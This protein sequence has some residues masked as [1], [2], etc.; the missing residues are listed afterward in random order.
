M[1]TRQRPITPHQEGI[2]IGAQMQRLDACTTDGRQPD[3]PE[4]VRAP[5]EMLEPIF[6]PRIE[7]RQR[8]SGVRIDGHGSISL[9][10]CCTA[11]NSS[12]G[13]IRLSVHTWS[14]V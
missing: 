6:S 2:R 12:R 10:N 14:A 9:Y 8:F 4:P 11:N 3:D 13:S 1:P 7:N 5:A